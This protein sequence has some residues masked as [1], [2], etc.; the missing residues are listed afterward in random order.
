MM[1]GNPIKFRG[2]NRHDSDPV[3]G[4]SIDCEQMNKDLQMMKQHN[5][6][7]I[8][9][10]HY[11]N[12]PYFYQLCD[13]YG[14]FVIDEA[15]N[16]SH[17]TQTQYLEDSEWEHARKRWNERIA[18]NPDFIPATVDRTQLCVH[19]DK[20]RPCVVIWSM[21]NEC[22]YGCT[23]EEALAWT[24]NF[25]PTRL[26]HYE[27]AIYHSDAR[28]YDFSNID[29]ESRMY[30]SFEEIEEYRNGNPS[31]PF[32]LVEYCHAMG[33]G[34][35]DLEDYFQIMESSDIMCG[36]FVWEWCDHAIYK[37]IADNGKAIYYYGGDH[38]ETIHDGNF[39]MDGLV[40]P[41]RTPHTGL[42]EF[43]NIH[44]PVRVI[45]F[46]QSRGELTLHNY[47]DFMELNQYVYVK[48]ELNCDGNIVAQGN[49][50]LTKAIPPHC[51]G[52]A[53]LSLRIPKQGK[54]YLKIRYFLKKEDALRQQ[55]HCLGFD[56]ILLSNEDGRNQKAL[57]LLKETQER[58]R[59]RK[60]L[61]S[62][63]YL[64]I[65]NDSIRYVYSKLTGM[66]EELV[67]EGKNLIIRSMEI[68]LWRA[69]TDNDRHIK[70]KW[71]AAHYDQTVTRAY[72]T[73]YI[74]KEDAIEIH[75]ILS[76]SAVSIQRILNIEATWIIGS[77]G[78]ISVN[79]HVKKDREFPELP[80][81]GLR[82]FLPKDMRQVTYYGVGP[83]ESYMDKHRACDHGE[84]STT[85]DEMH[86]DYLRPQENG[87][88]SDCD[89]VLLNGEKKI[90]IVVSKHPFAFHA[91]TYLQEELT[92][93]T[94][95]YELQEADCIELCL[96]YK[97]NGIGSASCGPQLLEEYRFDEEEFLF[98]MTLKPSVK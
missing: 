80:R 69:P 17:G 86:E 87:S 46:E 72:T 9:T 32:L 27:S 18:D 83:Y 43:K 51:E 89:Y 53:Q 28:E 1:N 56:E 47:M 62:D 39:C 10:S 81:F 55:G 45:N 58:K 36:G 25:D 44:R 94:H 31:K 66:F 75:S 3:T 92:T 97:Q 50:N 96:D 67:M 70:E 64:V 11:P 16:E 61:E 40:Y 76:V 30:S 29:L 38:G 74:E 60:V 8:R 41:D 7:S 49:V 48:Y 19:R 2:V 6:N 34:P 4:F 13:E 93:K 90:L 73:D 77:C 59:L 20:N 84:Y 26:T 37:G 95:N 24:K 22:A 68:N 63:R 65:E 42:L 52:K 21:G 14:F 35:G 82:L 33:N 98:E 79:M 88:H 71:L 5:F 54:C 85:V 15:D 57:G 78:Q 12:A 23:F 91:S